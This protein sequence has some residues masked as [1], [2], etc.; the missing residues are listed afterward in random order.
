MFILLSSPANEICDC[1]VNTCCVY[2][3]YICTQMPLG[4]QKV[5]GEKKNNNNS[6]D[7]KKLKMETQPQAVGQALKTLNKYESPQ[8]ARAGRY[9]W[10]T[11][12]AVL[13]VA[14][15]YMR[16]KHC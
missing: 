11:V 9:G 1:K 6:Q 3:N 4:L 13:A 7:T 16:R 5:K 8:G 15:C 2:E 12:R 14:Q 10:I